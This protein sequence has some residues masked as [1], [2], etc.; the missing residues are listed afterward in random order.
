[1]SLQVL[2]GPT[3]IKGE[4]LSDGLDCTAGDLLRLTMPIDWTPAPLTFQI[5]TDGGTYN[6]VYRLDGFE[7]TL[8]VIVPRSAIIVP[9]DVGKAIA[10]IKF[11]SGTA[12]N[13]VPQDADRTFAVAINTYISKPV[14]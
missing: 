14:D 3:I 7:V 4:S 11:R 8:P 2:I 10:W 12:A 13:P 6:D 5:S 9:A 1:M